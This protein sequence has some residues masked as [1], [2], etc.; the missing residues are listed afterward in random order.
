MNLHG[1]MDRQLLVSARLK[2][3]LGWSP[4]LNPERSFADFKKWADTYG[5]YW[6][7]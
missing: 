7:K 1:D 3:A 2:E 6:L 4:D 5:D